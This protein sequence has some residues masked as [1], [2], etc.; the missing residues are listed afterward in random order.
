MNSEQRRGISVFF[1]VFLQQVHPLKKIPGPVYVLLDFYRKH[2]S[3]VPQ[4]MNKA[5]AKA[6]AHSL[7]PC[8]DPA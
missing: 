5:P 1:G 2:G 7:E 8:V 6:E 3:I 4:K